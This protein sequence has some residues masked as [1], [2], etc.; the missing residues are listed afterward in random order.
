VRG[1]AEYLN[2]YANPEDLIVVHDTLIRFT[3]DYYYHGSTP[4][5]SLPLYYLVDTNAAID[6]L[7]SVVEPGKRIWFL[8]EPTPRNGIDRQVLIDWAEDNWPKVFERPFPRMWLQVGLSAFLPEPEVTS[9]PATTTSQAINWPGVLRMEGYE[10]PAE[11]TSGADLWLTFYLSQQQP[12]AKEHTLSLSFIDERGQEWAV[13]DKVIKRGFPPLTDKPG[14]VMRYDQQ[15]LL[16]AGLPPGQYQVWLRLVDTASGQVIPLD[17]GDL[18]VHLSDLAVQAVSCA[19]GDN[20]VPARFKSGARL[21]GEIELQGYDWPEEEYR[22][23]HLLPV[24]LWWCARQN[25]KSDYLLRLQL[26]DGAGQIVAESLES[27]GQLDYPPTQW[28]PGQLIMGQSAIVVPAQADEEEYQL[29]LSLVEPDTGKAIPVGWPFGRRSIPLGPVEVSPW[30]METKLPPISHSLR[31]D[32]GQPALVE[33]HGYEIS[34]MEIAPGDLVDISLIWRS[35][36]DSIPTSYAVFLHLVDEQGQILAQG[37][38]LPAGGFR[39]TTSWRQDEVI[40]DEHTIQVPAGLGPGTYDLWV[41][42][43][44]PETNERLPIFIDGVQQPDDRLLLERLEIGN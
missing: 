10:I 8:K 42:F 14:Q 37:D 36:V 13:V 21:R 22:P 15:F 39:P 25:P 26:R 40:V 29:H 32:I 6:D 30:P 18:D 38:G 41:G 24:T 16:P 9:I 20:Q 1:A 35:V 2:K 17:N 5:I 4:V 43:F 33:L 44:D 12:E 28:P 31:A 11:A 3:F 34:S 23:G 7:E 19:E 27:L